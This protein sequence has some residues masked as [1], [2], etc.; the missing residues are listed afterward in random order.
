MTERYPEAGS[1]FGMLRFVECRVVRP[2]HF[3]PSKAR[4]V[5]FLQ[6]ACFDSL[7][8][9]VKAEVS[10]AVCIRKC[11]SGN[12]FPD[13]IDRS[14]VAMAEVGDEGAKIGLE[15]VVEED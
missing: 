13:H 10:V 6:V 4:G 12:C 3:V 14:S 1:N 11:L 2:S 9:C 15:N 7:P 8:R 5:R